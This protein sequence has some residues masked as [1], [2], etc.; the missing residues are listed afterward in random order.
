[1]NRSHEDLLDDRNPVALAAERAGLWA[2][3]DA[4]ADDRV[5]VISPDD[6]IDALVDFI[7]AGPSYWDYELTAADT[8]V[9]ILYVGVDD[10][11]FNLPTDTTTRY[12]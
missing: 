3:I 6:S 8:G 5:A 7:N 2:E 9:P 10:D 4:D 11:P 12:M 1:M